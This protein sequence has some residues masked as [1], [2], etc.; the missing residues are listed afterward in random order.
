MRKPF[1]GVWNIIRFNWHFYVL[2]LALVIVLIVAANSMLLLLQPFIQLFVVLVVGSVFVSLL[3]SWYVY[4]VSGLY[5]MEWVDQEDGHQR[6]LNINAGFD[7]TSHLLKEKFK[8]AEFTLFDFYDPTKHT[9]V[10]IKRARKAYPAP[11]DTIQVTTDYLPLQDNSI[12]KIFVILAAHEVRDELERAVFFKELVRVLKPTG[13]IHITEH[14][15]DLPNFMAYTIG[16]F[17]FYSKKTWLKT[18]Q[19]AQLAVRS[20]KKITPFISTFI[21]VKNGSAY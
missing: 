15:R 20:E 7:E 4:D 10:S 8:G 9:E 6:I 14:L 2:A 1:Q 11:L 18:F 13:Q 16:F 17:H 19:N 12:D 3:A 21:L 5:E